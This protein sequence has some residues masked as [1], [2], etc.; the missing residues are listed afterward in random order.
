MRRP[1]AFVVAVGD[2]LVSGRRSDA[3]GAYLCHRFEALGCEIP[4]RAFVADDEEAV[5]SALRHALEAKPELVVVAGGLGSTEDDRTR[6]GIARALGLE[7]EVDEACLARIEQRYRDRGREVPDEARRQAMRPAGGE[8]LPN[9]VGATAGFVVRAARTLVF[10]LPGV[11]RQ[12]QALADR[13][14]FPR[15]QRDMADTLGA[16]ETTLHLVGISEDVV[17]REVFGSL[18]PSP[19]LRIG[20][21]A[22]AGEVAV[23]LSALGGDAEDARAELERAVGT[24]RGVFGDL[25]YGRDDESLV[26]VLRELM[27]ERGLTLG[28]AESCTGGLV[29]K[30]VTDESG[31]SAFFRGG[32][33]A[34]G[35]DVK[36]SS[37]DVPV[38]LLE[39]FGAVSAEVA[40][41]MASGVRARLGVSCGLST[42]GIAGPEGGSEEKPVGLVYIG[43]ATPEASCVTGFVLAGDRERIRRESAKLALDHLRRVLQGIDPLGEPWSPDDEA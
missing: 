29:A 24:L 37:L 32:V 3:N 22:T 31:A 15:L 6:A 9:P 19:T 38:D 10:A 21:R 40:A 42:T 35:N 28:C 4:S 27:V 20:L 5:A 26:R 30:T 43:A 39:R 34:Y 41:A 18:E 11:P 8:I 1:K 12:M 14:I 7:L 23:R 17:N 25:I 33:V 16:Q 13:E 36:A 2:E